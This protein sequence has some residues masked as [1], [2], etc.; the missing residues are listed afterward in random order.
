M[1]RTIE[2]HLRVGIDLPHRRVDAYVMTTTVVCDWYA[3]CTNE[4]AG[5]VDHPVLGA[6]PTCQRCA[7]KHELVVQPFSPPE[8]WD[9]PNDQLVSGNDVLIHLSLPRG[10][11]A[12]GADEGTSDADINEVTCEDCVAAHER[13]VSDNDV[14]EG[15]A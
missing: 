13:V 6:V 9:V 11:A 8:G 7:N 15:T 14:R 2:L 4:A 10:G 1:T 5:T 3:L 12:C